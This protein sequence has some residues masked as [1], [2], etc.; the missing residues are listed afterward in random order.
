MLKYMGPHG[1][2]FGPYHMEAN[3]QKESYST[4]KSILQ[5]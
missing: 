1:A 4:E 5:L 3:N 2:R